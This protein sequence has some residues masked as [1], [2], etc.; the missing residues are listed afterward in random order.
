[1]IVQQIYENE[2]AVLDDESIEIAKKIKLQNPKLPFII[3]NNRLV[4]DAYTVGSIQVLN[5]AINIL[6]RN[7]VFNLETIFQMILYNNG[8]IEENCKTTGYEYN[9]GFGATVLP[10]YFIET[11]KNLVNFGLTGG[12]RKFDETSKKL[13]GELKLQEYCPALLPITGLKYERQ[14]YLLNVAAN[15]II[16]SALAKL[17]KNKLAKNKNAELSMI[18]REFDSVDEYQGDINSLRKEDFNFSF[19]SANPYYPKT[20]EIA[21]TILKDMKISFYNGTIQWYSFLQNSNDLFESYIRKLV[22]QTTKLKVE[23]WESPQVYASLK[24]NNETGYKSYNPD[25]IIGYDNKK[26]SSKVVLDVKNKKF[27]P[28]TTSVSELVEPADLYQLLFYCRKQK[29]KL[30]ALI[31]PAAIDYEPINVIVNDE[32]DLRIVLL[33]VNMK[34]GYKNRQVK[35]KNEIYNSLLKYI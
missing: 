23:K 11:C 6:P 25:I 34:T 4:F 32:A 33:S 12:Y 31:Y 13:Q 8:I 20:L 3:D 2:D 1:M 30:G 16:K 17:S 28:N 19:F 22:G 5:T 9:S 35:L 27:E 15:Q 7:P 14:D 26:N 29:T 10:L 18:L 21:V 24:Y